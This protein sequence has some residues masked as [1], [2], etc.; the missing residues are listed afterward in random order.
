MHRCGWRP[1][2]VCALLLGT[3][4]ARAQSLPL[5]ELGGGAAAL[6]FP[7]YRG[8]EESRSYVLPVPWIVY[9][10]EILRADRD[11]VRATLF[12]SE[13]V[14][15]NISMNGSVPVRSDRNRARQGMEDLR[16]LLEVGPVANVRLWRSADDGA[17]L[18]L[19]VPVRVALA[20]RGGLRDIGYLTTPQLNLDLRWPT[21]T[22]GLRWNLGLVGAVVVADRRFNQYFYG[23]SAADATAT[24]PEYRATSGYGGWQAIAALSRRIDRFWLGGFI[25]YDD[26]SGARYEDSPL[27]TQRRQF[28]AGFAVTYIFA[29]SSRMVVP[30]D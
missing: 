30:R 16:P 17:A 1:L 26:L 14:E 20:F 23:V 25:K 10:G 12:D 21:E 11:G 6:R 19:R 15:F 7:D 13:R 3:T 29:T 28:S 22:P 24:R 18:E 27:V 4:G 5:W 8:S 2:F 9:R